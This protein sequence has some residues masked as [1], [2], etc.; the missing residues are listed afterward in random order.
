MGKDAPEGAR[1]PQPVPKCRRAG[2]I[3]RCPSGSGR[4]GWKRDEWTEPSRMSRGSVQEARKSL[5]SP[6]LRRTRGSAELP[7]KHSSKSEGARSTLIK[8]NL[9]ILITGGKR[10]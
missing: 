9:S 5:L 1:N 8:V 7:T 6:S 2:C 4:G 3:E 10:N